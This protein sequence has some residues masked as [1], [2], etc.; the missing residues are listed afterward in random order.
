MIE[1]TNNS[2]IKNIIRLKKS[3]KERKKQKQYVVEGPKMVLEAI[4][5]E[6]AEKIYV[7]E[8]LLKDI[9]GGIKALQ[10]NRFA[11]LDYAAV[12]DILEECG[13]ESVSDR[14]FK[15]LSDTVSPQGIIALAGIKDMDTK[16]V[17]YSQYG[18]RHFCDDVCCMPI[19]RILILE[20]I[21]DPGNL[22]TVFRTAEAA[23]FN[24]ILMNKGTV[25]VYN[26][27]TVRSTMGAVF[28]LPFA[29]GDDICD[30]IAECK[31]TGITVYGTGLLGKDIRDTEYKPCSAFVIGNESNGM[32]EA[33]LNVC[34]E[35]IKIP[36]NP[37]SESLNAGVAA[38]IIMYHSSLKFL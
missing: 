23:G 34:D 10:N 25:D 18:V 32:S 20:D 1:S 26:P 15:E 6:L 38:G 9:D 21:Q 33:A 7:A 30:I 37:A 31:K 2:Q 13:Y 28:R 16:D 27:K 14:V 17:L 36:M 11:G 3:G 12:F 24:G 35:N 8:S 19:A 22:G 5:L 29:Y 4:K